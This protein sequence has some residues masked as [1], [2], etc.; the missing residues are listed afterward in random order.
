MQNFMQVWSSSR[1]SKEAVTSEFSLAGMFIKI[2][3]AKAE[4]KQGHT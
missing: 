3:F 4:L 2:Y 1:I